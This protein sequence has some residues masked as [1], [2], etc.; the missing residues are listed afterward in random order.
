[1]DQQDWIALDCP[2]CGGRLRAQRSAIGTTVGCPTCH[3]AV[4]VRAPGGFGGPMIIDSSRKLG[5][6]PE[7]DDQETE[8]FKGRLRSSSDDNYKVDPDNPVMKRRDTRKAKHGAVLT[9][10][11]STGRVPSQDPGKNQRRLVMWLTV[12][13]AVLG[14]TVVGIL[15][16]RSG[17]LF[18]PPAAAAAS[19]RHNEEMPLDLQSSADFRNPV[20]QVVSQFCS[21][22][23]AADLLPVI[24][25]PERVGPLLRNWYSTDERKWVPIPVPAVPDPVQFETDGNWTAFKLPMPDF[26]SRSMAVEKTDRGFKVD[27][28]SF[29]AYSEMSWQDLQQIRPKTPTLMRVICRITGYYNLDF[30]S[31]ETWQC[32]ELTD[33]NS[34]NNTV[35]GYV[36]RGSP[37]AVEMQKLM[38]NASN[39]NAVLRV[40]YPARSTTLTQVDIVEVVAKGWVIREQKVEENASGSLLGDPA[41]AAQPAPD[42][43][44][45]PGDPGASSVR[46]PLPSITGP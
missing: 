24:R 9:G 28:E 8:A 32:F 14:L 30:P 38:L 5:V 15:I 4:K 12:V 22:Q 21:A 31:E 26:G 41:E 29:V 35:Y 25:D 11:D 42:S 43:L 46:K 33:D 20:W 16:S 19:V 44:S 40:A 2:A 1:M 10:W 17:S 45:A 27:W 37:T 18:Q 39:V 6:S 36:K 23:T 13:T 34:R 7:R 3:A